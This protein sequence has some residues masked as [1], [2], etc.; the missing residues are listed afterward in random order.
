MQN[1]PGIIFDYHILTECTGGRS[2]RYNINGSCKVDRILFADDVAL[3]FKTK[4]D[5]KD[6]LET[7]DNIFT[8]YG[9]TP[10]YN[11]TETMVVNGTED[12][13]K[14]ESLVEIKGEEI[15]N[16]EKF[17]YS[18]NMVSPKDIDKSLIDFRINSARAKY[19]FL[20][21]VF[22]NKRLSGA[23]KEKYLNTFIRSRLCYGC[24]AW[25]L[26]VSNRILPKISGA[27]RDH[28]NT[29]QNLLCCVHRFESGIR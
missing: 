29:G 9:L 12:E 6:A 20:K 22:L 8:E 24:P 26:N 4:K 15:K 18:G 3:L 21:T 25:D 14:L 13:A 1:S 10:T 17:K 19:Y 2:K 11:K 16:T 5:M 7:A 28:Q 23:I 27:Y